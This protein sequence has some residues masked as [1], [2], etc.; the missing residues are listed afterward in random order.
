MGEL[1]GVSIRSMLTRFSWCPIIAKTATK[2]NNFLSYRCFAFL[3]NLLEGL[4]FFSVFAFCLCPLFVS[5]LVS[6]CAIITASA[7]TWFSCGYQC[8]IFWL[9]CLSVCNE[10][11]DTDNFFC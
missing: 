1:S 5:S 3:C 9:P 11:L 6:K 10:V 2:K 8:M 7:F 4:V